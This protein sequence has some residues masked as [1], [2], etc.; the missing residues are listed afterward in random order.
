MSANFTKDT[1]DKKNKIKKIKT[2]T[3]LKYLS[4]KTW[5]K[6]MCPHEESNLDLKFRKL[7]LYPLSYGDKLKSY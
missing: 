3:T 4:F 2:K 6:I 7:T 5:K 1:K